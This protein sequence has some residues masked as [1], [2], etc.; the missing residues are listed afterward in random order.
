MEIILYIVLALILIV[1][2]Y[3][4]IKKSDTNLP[5]ESSSIVRYRKTEELTEQLNKESKLRI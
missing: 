5:D 2:L 3:F 1:F 4:L